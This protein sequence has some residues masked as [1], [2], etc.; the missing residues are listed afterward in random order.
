M[1]PAPAVTDL[2]ATR[3][4]GRHPG[5]SHS[6]GE[7]FDPFGFSSAFDAYQRVVEDRTTVTDDV[8]RLLLEH[9]VDRVLD[10][11]A[12]TGLPALDLRQRG[13]RIDCSDGD[14]EMVAQFQRNAKRNRVDDRCDVRCWSQLPELGASYDYLLCRGNSLVYATTWRGGSDV[15]PAHL[16]GKYLGSFRSVLRPGGT[17]HVDV[18]RRLDLQLSR[19]QLDSSP[20]A[21]LVES[22]YEGPLRRIAVA[23]D[24]V[25]EETCRRWRVELEVIPETGQPVQ[26][27]FER[28]SSRLIVDDLEPMLVRA[29]FV[30][31]ERRSLSSDRPSHVTVLARNPG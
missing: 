15:A 23:E 20:L 19:R 10:C 3:A 25:E 1:A 16:L 17:L 2:V 22:E 11:A 4:G 26:V 13:V 29:G 8:H 18:P 6:T 5:T 12:G 27:E 30:D 14:P 21:R 31:I 9:D 24:V 28:C 7:S